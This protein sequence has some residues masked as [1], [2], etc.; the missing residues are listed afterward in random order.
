MIGVRIS[1]RDAQLLDPVS[2]TGAL[3]LIRLRL[4]T[5]PPLLEKV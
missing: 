2:G 4:T 5:L 3:A 1:L